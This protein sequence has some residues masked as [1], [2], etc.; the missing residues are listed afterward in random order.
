MVFNILDCNC[1]HS[2]GSIVTA[3]SSLETSCKPYLQKTITGL[4][5]F[6]CFQ[7]LDSLHSLVL[8]QRN[9]LLGISKLTQGSKG[10]FFFIFGF[11]SLSFFILLKIFC[12]YTIHP[13]CNFPSLCFSMFL[14]S[15]PPIQ[16]HYLS[17][18]RTEWASRR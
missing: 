11:S 17:L 1:V 8:K 3:Y 5:C 13:N 14:L 2:E 18:I 9:L 12:S 6:F 10:I 16:M 15:F 4:S 7:T